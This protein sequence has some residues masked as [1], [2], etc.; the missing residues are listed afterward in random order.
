MGRSV[1]P[2]IEGGLLVA[3]TVI[4]GLVSTYIPL[5]GIFVEFFSAVPLA[6]LTVRRGAAKGLGGLFVASV[7]LAILIGPFL[8]IRLALSFGICGVTF[9]FCVRKNFSAVRI[10][11]TT[12]AVA[13]AAQ[14]VSLGLLLAL[15]DVNF[16][17]TQIELLRVSFDESFNFYEAMGVD[18][19]RIDEAKAQVETG[20]QTLSL[21]MPT[22]I[23][24]GALTDSLVIWFTSKWIFPKVQIKLPPF[25]S[26]AQW[27]FPSV[28][29]YTAIIG[30]LGIYWGVTRGWTGI[31]EI[32]LNLA[33]VSMF[34]GLVQGLS[35][36]SFVFD[37][38]KISKFPRRIFYVLIIINALFLQL[39]AI[40]G[41]VDMLFDYRKKLLS[42]DEETE[43]GD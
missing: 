14:I 38:Y 18:K 24:F 4:M 31:E 30:G 2:T 16:I 21:L 25:P 43:G 1:T 7:L 3:I 34:V 41:L 8:S 37:R 40:T 29:L 17:E 13:S 20:I 36:L 10:F 32:S 19:A 39:V 6:I 27:K 35:L 28:F 42:R 12:F 11:F 5:L 33:A 22:I 9:G 26:F 15:V 23:M